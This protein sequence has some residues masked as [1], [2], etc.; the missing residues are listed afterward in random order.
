M[1]SHTDGSDRGRRLGWYGAI[2]LGVVLVLAIALLMRNAPSP[3]TEGPSREPRIVSLAPSV[4]EM[5]F[6]L[7]RQG[8]IVGVTDHCDYPPAAKDIERVGG[9]GGPNIET[10]LSM[11]PDLVITTGLE[12][13]DLAEAIRQSGIRLLDVRIKSFQDLFDAFV[14]V[15]EEVGRGPR[16]REIVAA[17]QKE[18]EAVAAQHAHT[19]P[20]ERPTVFV[21]L[22][23]DPISTAG[24]TSFVNE[25]IER[26][27]GV[28]VARDVDQPYPHINPEKVIE[29]DPDVI[30]LC[31]MTEPGDMDEQMSDRIGWADIRAVKEKRIVC[32]I[33]SS[34]L[35]RPGPR[36]V[37]GVK[38]LSERLYER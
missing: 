4:T 33:P 25:V 32:D 38:A 5:L 20:E 36:L 31:Y 6:A 11:R 15:G 2:A 19:P 10:L 35:L 7:D 8:A 16:A 3:H 37:D 9:L 18:L 23:H 14:R 1:T 21:E 26:A 22:W 12:R 28:N 34:L 27:G 30:L 29:W 17:L 13:S 24:R